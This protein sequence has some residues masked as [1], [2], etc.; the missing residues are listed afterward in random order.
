[1]DYIEKQNKHINEK[2]SFINTYE[3][4]LLAQEKLKDKKNVRDLYIL[5]NNSFLATALREKKV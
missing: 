5:S 2:N 4:S 3:K 1:M